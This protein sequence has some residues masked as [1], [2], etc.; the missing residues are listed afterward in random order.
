[1]AS[2]T[3]TSA[4]RKSLLSCA[5]LIV[6]RRI[7]R[8]HSRRARRPAAATTSETPTKS[9][10]RKAEP[11]TNKTM[12]ISITAERPVRNAS[13]VAPA[14]PRKVGRTR[15]NAFRTPKPAR[16]SSTSTAAWPSS[17]RISGPRDQGV[18]VELLDRAGDQA[19]QA[20]LL[21]SREIEDEQVGVLGTIGLEVWEQAVREPL[22]D[23]L[24]DVRARNDVESLSGPYPP[25]DPL[26]E[27]V[28]RGGCAG[29]L[30]L[31]RRQLHPLSP[32]VGERRRD[33]P[34]VRR[35]DDVPE[36]DRHRRERGRNRGEAGASTPDR[37][38]DRARGEKRGDLEHEDHEGAMLNGVGGPLNRFTT[39]A[40]RRGRQDEGAGNQVGDDVDG[41]KDQ[42]VGE[43]LRR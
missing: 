1:T 41:V 10:R 42:H 38:H 19:R 18:V 7:D 37:R 31:G 30:L 17:V 40:W 25:A 4:A 43:G 35:E 11:S 36:R 23:G 14:T 22:P 9:G 20:A 34:D 24:V 28:R 16:S 27:R 13:P 32:L 15:P 29:Q 6:G 26:D 8:N 39:Q 12:P 2:L 5:R 21:R 33:L 3:W